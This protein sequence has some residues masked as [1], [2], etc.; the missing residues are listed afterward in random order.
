MFLTLMLANTVLG[1]EPVVHGRVVGVTDGD[2]IKVLVADQQLLRVRLAFCDA[3]EKKQAFGA[4]AKQA[5]S[6]LVFGR[7]VELRPHAIDRYGRTVAQ[8][9]SNHIATLINV[10][11]IRFSFALI[12]FTT[13]SPRWA[14]HQPLSVSRPF[15]SYVHTRK[16]LWEEARLRGRHPRKKHLRGRDTK[17]AAILQ[18]IAPGNPNGCSW[19]RLP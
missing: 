16:V 12:D 4:R 6:E 7:E 2:T 18:T 9:G 1:Q 17:R 3:P 15:R 10:L 8:V 11:M 13:G 5:M 19:R 14:E